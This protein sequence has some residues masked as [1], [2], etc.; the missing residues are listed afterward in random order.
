MKILSQCLA[1][2]ALTSTATAFVPGASNAFTLSQLNV[3]GQQA[4]SFRPAAGIQKSKANLPQIDWLADG[5]GSPEN[6]INL[7]EYIKQVL[8][9]MVPSERLRMKNVQHKLVRALNK[10]LRM[11]PPIAECL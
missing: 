3:V 7:L 8:A 2:V 4:E 9:I 1:I 6:K 5:G 11:R 10:Q